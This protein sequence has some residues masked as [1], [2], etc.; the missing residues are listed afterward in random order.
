ML[1]RVQQFCHKEDG[2]ITVDWVVLTAGIAS[3]A[4]AILVL[5]GTETEDLA[6]SVGTEVE[7]VP[8]VIFD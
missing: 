5:A 8:L 2:A 4:V 6:T 7:N 1:H 3:L